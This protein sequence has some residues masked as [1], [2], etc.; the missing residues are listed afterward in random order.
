MT[1]SDWISVVLSVLSFLLAAL[2][3]V[4]VVLTIRQNNKMIKNSTRAYIVVYGA[5]TYYSSPQFYLV[6]K[7][8]GS[9]GAVITSL[10]CSIDLSKYSYVDKF[11]PFGDIENTNIA[12]NQNYICVL[13]IDKLEKDSID[14]FLITI[15]YKSGKDTYDETYPINYLFTKHN[16]IV[17]TANKGNELRDISY[18]L[19]DIGKKQL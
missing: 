11:S 5:Y 10:K 18:V 16:V 17:T 14:N 19:Q 4:F 13:S 2:S 12:P 3:I 1:I 9:S 7:N 15:T 8:F 6:V